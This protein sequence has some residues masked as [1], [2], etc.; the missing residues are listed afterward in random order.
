MTN[1]CSNRLKNT[2]PPA[3]IHSPTMVVFGGLAHIRLNDVHL[4]DIGIST[5]FNNY[6]FLLYFFPFLFFFYSFL[7]AAFLSSYYFSISFLKLFYI[8]SLPFINMMY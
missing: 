4:L 8:C 7:F 6:L 3:K 2:P 5:F 1:E